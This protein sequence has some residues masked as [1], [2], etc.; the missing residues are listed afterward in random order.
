PQARRSLAARVAQSAAWLVIVVAILVWVG[1]QLA[2]TILAAV[3][4][5]RRPEHAVR[6]DRGVVMATSD[7]VKLLAD[8]YHPLRITRAPT[9]L[10]RIPF[11]KTFTNSLFAT[12]V[13]RFWAERGYV[14]VIQGTRG[15]YE[16]G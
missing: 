10:V 3:L 15:R 13:G 6:I 8:V 9:I 1:Y 12:V 4:A 2:P 14:V 7:G 16:S 5:A 11:S